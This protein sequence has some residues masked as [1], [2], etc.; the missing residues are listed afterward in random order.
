MSA[1]N[2]VLAAGVNPEKLAN[3]RKWDLALTV[4]HLG[5]AV[6]MLLLTNNFALNVL[7]SFPG[8]W[9]NYQTHC[10]Q[11]QASWTKGDSQPSRYQQGKP[12]NSARY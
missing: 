1:T 4:L 2:T 8:L 9:N 6:A 5:Q 3:V 11:Y 10:I 12:S 7:S